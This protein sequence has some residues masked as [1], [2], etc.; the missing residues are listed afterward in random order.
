MDETE[1][2]EHDRARREMVHTAQTFEG[3]YEV[4][5]KIGM[6]KD[7]GRMYPPA[8]LIESIEGVRKGTVTM[9]FIPRT[10]GLREKVSSLLGTQK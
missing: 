1:H 7:T 8:R 6:V 3:L 2:T 4:L 9:G 10:Y 5:N